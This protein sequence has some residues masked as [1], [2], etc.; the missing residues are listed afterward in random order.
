[1]KQAEKA[2]GDSI[3]L[4]TMLRFLPLGARPDGL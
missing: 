2:L 4:Q 1:M 3:L